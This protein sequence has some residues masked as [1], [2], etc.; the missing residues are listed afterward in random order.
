MTKKLKIFLAFLLVFALLFAAVFTVVFVFFTDNKTDLQPENETMIMP[1]TG[2][3]TIADGNIESNGISLMSAK[4][5]TADYAAYGISPQAETGYLITATVYPVTAV[6]LLD[7]TAEFKNAN[8]SWA[9]GKTVADYIEVTPTSDGAL[10]ARVECL[11]AFSEQIIIKATSRSDKTVY[12]T[13]TVDYAKRFTTSQLTFTSTEFTICDDEKIGENVAIPLYN[14]N[15]SSSNWRDP[16]SSGYAQVY[17]F[18]TGTVAPEIV[19]TKIEVKVS[20]TFLRLYNAAPYYTFNGNTTEC[21]YKDWYTTGNNGLIFAD[22]IDNMS[23]PFAQS[24]GWCNED[25]YTGFLK[26]LATYNSTDFYVRITATMQYGENRVEEVKEYPCIFYRNSEV[27]KAS[28]LSLDKSS[29]V[30]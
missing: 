14:F 6:A 2:G 24:S 9:N 22:L 12:G 30:C 5:A 10:T 27:F 3:M 21:L 7:W 1:D 20:D 15:S 11:K 17:C 29:L 26:A 25:D 4:I 19:S 16:E 13:C 18:G 23:K 8:S 28:S